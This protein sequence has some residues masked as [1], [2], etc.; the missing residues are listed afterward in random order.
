M[1]AIASSQRTRRRIAMHGKRRANESI[2]S[3]S[4][5][6]HDSIDDNDE[7]KLATSGET[8]QHTD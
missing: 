6:Q 7:S 4:R 2:A 3:T 8:H 1:A 5:G